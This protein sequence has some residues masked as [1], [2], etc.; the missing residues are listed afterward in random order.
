M[1]RSA[2]SQ[3]ELAS[4]ALDAFL[5]DRPHPAAGGSRLEHFGSGQVSA[6]MA[7]TDDAE[8]PRR[9]SKADWAP[10]KDGIAAASL[11]RSHTDW[12]R[13]RLVVT[14]STIEVATFRDAASGAG[15]IPWCLDLDSLQEDWFH[16]LV[17]PAGNELS[18]AGARVLAAQ[19]REAVE[20]RHALAVSRVGRSCACP[21]DLH[22][23]V[24]VPAAILALGPDHPDALSWQWQHWGTTEPLRHVVAEPAGSAARRPD[25]TSS[26]A[27]WRLSFWSADW[28]PWRAI[29]RVRADWPALR[30]DVR[31]D[32]T[33][34]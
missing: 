19:L 10:I 23:L 31:P 26:E 30:F 16:L 12:L 27:A 1:A 17:S 20:R 3:A 21:L 9:T 6:G 14:G 32:Y 13:H 28:T 4:E 18:L 29:A 25:A 7:T 8:P 33:A 15:T 5:R 24:P 22:S 34:G 11:R 2:A